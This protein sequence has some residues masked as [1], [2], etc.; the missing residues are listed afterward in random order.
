ML[1]AI[2]IPS[3]PYACV[4]PWNSSSVKA[5][6]TNP[7][8]VDVCVSCSRKDCAAYADPDPDPDPEPGAP[9]G[10]VFAD[11]SLL[12]CVLG[13]EEEGPAGLLLVLDARVLARSGL[14]WNALF[15]RPV[16][17]VW[18]RD[19][20]EGAGGAEVEG[21]LLEGVNE[22]E[23]EGDGAGTGVLDLGLGLP[24]M[25]SWLVMA[26]GFWILGLRLG[27]MRLRCRK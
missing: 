13:R 12:V 27:S 18:M 17:E 2:P 7:P 23:A 22:V 15:A 8:G 14:G 11:R 10:V 5:G 3:Y 21:G 26:W 24:R 1:S 4:F 20:S 25:F 19:T 9:C 6:R 16:A